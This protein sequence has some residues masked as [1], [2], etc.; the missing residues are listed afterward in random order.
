MKTLITLITAPVWWIH[1]FIIDYNAN[2][3][4]FGRKYSECTIHHLCE[5]DGEL[6][7]AE[8][9]KWWEDYDHEQLDRDTRSDDGD[10]RWYHL[11]TEAGYKGYEEYCD[12]E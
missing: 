11:K 3:D 10:S 1:R 12:Y 4:D 7:D 8:H 6:F 2:T 5:A 9:T